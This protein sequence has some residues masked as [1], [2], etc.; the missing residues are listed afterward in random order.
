[1]EAKVSFSNLAAAADRR[2]FGQASISGGFTRG[3]LSLLSPLSARTRELRPLASLVAGERGRQ[4]RQQEVVSL[5][6][7][8]TMS[9]F[10]SLSTR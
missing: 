9:S 8:K 5:L 1:M 2:R 6:R 3:K 10:V 4:R 7:E